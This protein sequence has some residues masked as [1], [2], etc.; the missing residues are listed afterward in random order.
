MSV[1]TI[2]K[3]KKEICIA[4]DG[5]VTFGS[6]KIAGTHITHSDKLYQVNNS[7]I[8]IV[9][10]SAVAMILEHLIST[11]PEIFKLNSRL[12][13]YDTLLKLQTILK[14]N[15]FIETGDDDDER[16]VQTN[17][18]HALI[19]NKNGIFSVESYREVMEF[20]D[21]WAAGSGYSFAIGAMHALYTTDFSARQIAEAGVQAAIEYNDGCGLPITSKSIML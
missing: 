14:E 1:I 5:Q 17:H 13:I 8:G 21:Y 18:L 20:S 3:T 9:G 19:A 7:V 11:K 4:A 12:E 10:W 16:P 15:Y 2:V 6:T